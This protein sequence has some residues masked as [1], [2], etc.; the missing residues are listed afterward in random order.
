MNERRNE[1]RN[2]GTN[3]EGTNNERTN[4]RRKEYEGMLSYFFTEL[5]HPLFYNYIY[6]ITSCRYLPATSS[7]TEGILPA[8]SQA[9]LLSR[10]LLLQPAPALSYTI[11][12]ATSS[13]ASVS[14]FL[15]SRRHCIAF[16]QPAAKP[17]AIPQNTRL[18]LC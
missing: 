16:L 8:A 11:L 17:A 10:L 9:C 12:S 5:Y 18:A 4:E 1:R 15:S 14:Q 6:I 2:E 3:N 7:L 13:I